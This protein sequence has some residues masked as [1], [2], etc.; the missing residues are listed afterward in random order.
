MISYSPFYHLFHSNRL[1]INDPKVSAGE[2]LTHTPSAVE[3]NIVVPIIQTQA[4]LPD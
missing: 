1:T 3:S 4:Q 2:V